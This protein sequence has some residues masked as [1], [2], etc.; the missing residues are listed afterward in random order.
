MYHIHQQICHNRVHYRLRRI[1]DVRT[2]Y[3]VVQCLIF[4]E[5]VG[6]SRVTIQSLYSRVH[7]MHFLQDRLIIFDRFVCY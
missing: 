2:K 4:C 7:F 5:Q 3:H 6:T 1:Q